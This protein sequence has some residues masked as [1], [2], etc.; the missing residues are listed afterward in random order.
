M[1]RSVAGKLTALAVKALV[2]PGR[3]TDGG[4]LML[5]VRAPSA[6][7]REPRRSWVLRYRSGTQRRDMGLGDYPDISLAAAREKAGIARELIRAGKDP[8]DERRAGRVA[9]I[10]ARE[11]TFE[12]AAKDLMDSKAAEFRNAKH[13]AQWAST[14]ETYAY[15]LLGKMPVAAITTDHV[16]GVLRTTTLPAGEKAGP[17]GPMP[18]WNRAPET[19]A[20]VRGRIEAVL[21]AAA[22]RHWREGPNPARW[23]GH[24][25]MLLPR[26]KAER[27]VQHHPA[28]PFGQMGDFMAALAERAGTAAR[29]LEFTILTAA[30]SGE[31]R[32]MTWGEVDLEAKVWTVPAERMKAARQ[33]RV[34]LSPQAVAIL[35]AARPEKPKPG[36]LVFPS[37]RPA[38]PLSD[39]TLSAVVRRMNEP[40]EGEPKDSPPRWRDGKGR[41]VVPHGFRSTFRDWCGETRSDPLV[42]TELCLAHSVKSETQ[43][44]YD[45]GDYL[46]RRRPLMEAWGAFCAASTAAKIDQLA[47]S[48]G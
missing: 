47:R 45:R 19:A 7:G 29:A 9:T 3:Y 6:A 21:N 42:V 40:A 27:R 39:M 48:A 36:A 20:R 22:V 30:R 33:H 44:A 32:G 2:K 1:G 28:L 12:A 43:E 18:L 23:K 10:E 38:K 17:D 13:R 34:P 31:V 8:L 14:L 5:F 11:R 26:R 25:E 24:L 15:P 16:L 46:E 37:E 41:A 35:L 4:G